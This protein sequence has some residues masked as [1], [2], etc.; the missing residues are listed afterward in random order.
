MYFSKFKKWDFLTKERETMTNFDKMVAATEK[1]P[2]I[3]SLILTEKAGNIEYDCDGTTLG[4]CLYNNG[5]VA[6]QRIFTSKGTYFPEHKH[7]EREFG[8]VYNGEIEVKCTGNGIFII[9]HEY[10]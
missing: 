3:E 4:F 5:N 10:Q 1:L 7:G 8:I 2:P 6:V 9:N